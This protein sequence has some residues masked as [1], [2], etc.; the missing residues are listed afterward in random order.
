[1]KK[2]LLASNGHGAIEGMRL[3]FDDVKEM[4]LAYITTGSN[5]VDDVSYIERH[6]KKMDELGIDY[7]EVD[8]DG[9]DESA[10]R[11]AI[12]G[13]NAIYVEGGNTFY[14]LKVI[15]ESGFDSAVKDFI[16]NGGVYIGSSAGAYVAC[17]TIEMSTW[18]ET[19]KDRYGV[20]DFT[21]LNLVPFLVFAHYTDDLEKVIKG[22]VEN[23][24]Y[25]VKILRDGQS[26]LVEGD[27]VSLVGDGKE[28]VL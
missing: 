24:K 19:Q 11:N 26:V 17:P 28:V 8:I 2:I 1:M 12:S 21:A 22:G 14:L 5:G 20:H 13:K 15:R 10:V 18:K 16:A 6:K 23:A 9:M 3:L 27:K 4:R 7:V 25:P